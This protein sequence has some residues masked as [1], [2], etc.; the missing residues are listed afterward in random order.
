MPSTYQELKDA[1]I[2]FANNQVIEQSLDTFIDLCE[3]DISRRVRHWR[4]E[5]RATADLD[6]QYTSLP[7]DFLE[8]LRMS[9][10]SSTTFALEPASTQEIA[11]K[12][13]RAS[14]TA[15]RP[16]LYT[17][18]D[19][20][21]EVWP[22]PDITYTLQ[23]VYYGRVDAL[24]SVN[25]TNWL[26]TYFPDALL[27]GTLLHAAPYMGEDQRIQIWSSL[28]DKAVEAINQDSQNAKFGGSGLRMKMRSY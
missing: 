25:T 7:T 9:I 23:M 10:T 24:S 21:I 2:A 20:T 13:Q 17:I 14:D 6:S 22:K 1:V 8:P 15:S 3:A 4:M 27:Y 19:E 5:K 28:Y 11:L 16:R 12:R 18:L 26:L